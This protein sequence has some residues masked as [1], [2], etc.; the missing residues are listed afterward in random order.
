[1][2]KA[3]TCIIV[4][5]LLF[6]LYLFMIYPSF[7]SHVNDGFREYL[8]TI[9]ICGKNEGFMKGIDSP[10]IAGILGKRTES[11]DAAWQVVPPKCEIRNLNVQGPFAKLGEHIVFEP[12]LSIEYIRFAPSQM[13]FR[14]KPEVVEIGH[15]DFTAKMHYVTLMRMLAERNPNFKPKN[16]LKS[17]SENVDLSG[18]L[19]EVNSTV[20][21]S[22]PVKV[23]A[24]GELEMTIDEIV[25]FTNT[26]V[27]SET[28]RQKV[29]NALDLRWKFNV[30]G[31]D[32]E[33]DRAALSTEGLY[34]EAES[35][36]WINPKYS[37]K[38]ADKEDQ[39]KSEEDKNQ[40]EKQETERTQAGD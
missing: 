19:N 5:I 1:M 14:S 12:Y 33:L 25:N 27:T 37:K 4:L 10:Q 23:N 18:F 7:N 13:M 9:P 26:R 34:I 40:K 35:S 2:K 8:K 30:L 15:V 6:F 16:M 21:L 32:L 28:A 38:S 39:A 36:G 3:G 17:V 24:A 11:Y 29:I 20:Y 31:V 22:G